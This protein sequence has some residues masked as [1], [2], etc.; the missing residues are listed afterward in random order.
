MSLLTFGSESAKIFSPRKQDYNLTMILAYARQG[1]A[2][3]SLSTTEALVVP[4]NPVIIL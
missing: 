1:W 3:G 2:W 4:Y